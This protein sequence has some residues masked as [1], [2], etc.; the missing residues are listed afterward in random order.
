MGV[1]FAPVPDV[2]VYFNPRCSKCREMVSL[3]DDAGADY[4]LV[5]YLTAPPDAATIEHLLDLLG[6]DPAELVRTGDAGFAEAGY[7]PT[8]VADRA[9]VV[10]VLLAHP[11]F[12]QRPVVVRGDRA[13]IA[14]PPERARAL[15]D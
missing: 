3:L 11:E 4:G 8:D 14:R 7:R 9:G 1:R 5:E 15:L 13:V 6:G 2:A 12:M 10:R